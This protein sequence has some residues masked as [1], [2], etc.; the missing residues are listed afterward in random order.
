[1]FPTFSLNTQMRICVLTNSCETLDSPPVTGGA[2]RDKVI[3]NS[4]VLHSNIVSTNRMH[5][6][7]PGYLFT[8]L[9]LVDEMRA[10][11]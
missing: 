10:V 8:W 4:Q 5:S 2:H 9:D 6:Y 3:G 7:L 11:L 1:M